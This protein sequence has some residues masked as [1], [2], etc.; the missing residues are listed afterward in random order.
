MELPPQVQEQRAKAQE[1]LVTS[2]RKLDELNQQLVAGNTAAQQKFLSL[3]ELIGSLKAGV[4]R[5]QSQVKEL[6]SCG[7]AGRSPGKRGPKSAPGFPGGRELCDLRQ[8]CVCGHVFAEKIASLP[9]QPSPYTEENKLLKKA[10]RTLLA[11]LSLER[12]RLGAL[13]EQLGL[14]LKE[15]EQLEQ[16]LRARALE[17]EAAV[18]DMQRVLQSERLLVPGIEELVPDSLWAPFREPGRS[19]LEAMP[20]AVPEAQRRP[21]PEPLRVPSSLAGGD[22]AKSHEGTCIPKAKAAK[23]SG[24]PRLQEPVTQNS[25]LKARSEELLKECQQEKG[26]SLSH[27]AVRIARAPPPA[28]ASTSTPP[29]RYKALFKEIFSC[30]QKRKQVDK[31]RGKYRSLPSP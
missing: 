28:G 4:H 29:P 21:L 30:I 5:L 7:Q 13:E 19:L 17:L 20:L 8:R 12:R 25:A 23:Q 18:A 10:L 24:V 2:T 11:Q 9:G 26:D 31:R 1:H 27:K 15:N 6:E 16:Q 14:V 3:I 22:I